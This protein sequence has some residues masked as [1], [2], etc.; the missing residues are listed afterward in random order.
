MS[1]RRRL[2]RR[3]TPNT[4]MDTGKV[5]NVECESVSVYTC[6]ICV[7]TL[8]YFR[9]IGHSS[10]ESY[11]HASKVNVSCG[12]SWRCLPSIPSESHHLYRSR[13]VRL[14]RKV[15]RLHPDIHLGSGSEIE[16]SGLRSSD[17]ADE[18]VGSIT[19]LRFV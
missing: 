7:H 15:P 14:Y 3:K 13:R 5:R 19:R 17:E 1:H 9:I 10:G 18:S 4:G 6:M 11:T 8:M 2:F 12:Y 16:L